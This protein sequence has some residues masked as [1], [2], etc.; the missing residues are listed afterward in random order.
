MLKASL[1]YLH[2]QGDHSFLLRSFGPEA[3]DAPYHF[4]TA[5]ELTYITGGRGKRYIGS[6]QDNFG[7]GDLVLIG[8]DIPHCWKLEPT[9]SSDAGAIVV[10]FSEDTLGPTL[11]AKTE[12]EAVTK[13]LER[14]KIGIYFTAPISDQI[15]KRLDSLARETEFY[16]FTGLL[17]VLQQLSDDVTCTVFSQQDTVAI[18]PRASQQRISP[19]FAYLV[20]NYRSKVSLEE[21]A[22]L[23]HMTPQAFCK[24]FKKTT[25]KTFMETVMEYR[26]N[27]AAQ[28]LIQ[29]EK[30]VSDISFQS[31]FSDV[32]FF[33]RTF[34]RKM[35]LSPLNYR[36]R[37][38][39]H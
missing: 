27:Y 19:V 36:R 3:F 30:P 39:L 12:M 2:P 38:M 22:S 34:K 14:A 11:L 37:F 29:T 26:I 35:K 28:Q 13:F 17:E 16:R 10:H 7:P 9:D 24:Y 33:Y 5:Y 31:G 6:H 1:E 25:R 4:H 20:E 15:G 8:P 32:S 18:Q 21:A 23:A